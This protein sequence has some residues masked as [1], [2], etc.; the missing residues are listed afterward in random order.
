MSQ[1]SSFS[2]NESTPGLRFPASTTFL[3]VAETRQITEGKGR[4]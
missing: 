2:R 3:W 1:V 4:P